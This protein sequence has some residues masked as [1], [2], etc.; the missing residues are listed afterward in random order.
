MTSI[1]KELSDGPQGRTHRQQ[2][3]GASIEREERS[4]KRG[5]R[6]GKEWKKWVTNMWVSLF[7][8]LIEL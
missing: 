3:V 4:G 7:F 5:E 6:E 1:E 8:S 2:L